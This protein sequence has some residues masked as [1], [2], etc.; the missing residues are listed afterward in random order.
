MRLG[1]LWLAG[2]LCAPA[3]TFHLT[4]SGLG[5][6]AD[7]EQRFKMWADDIGKATHTQAMIAP[8]RDA[9]R[10]RLAELAKQVKADD[11]FVLMLIGHG[12]FDGADYKFNL[13]GPDITATELALLLDRIPATRQMV[14]NMTSCS[15]GASDLL[16]KPTRVV[17]SATKSGTE[18]NATVFARYW[19]EALRDATA[20]TDKNDTV[21]A[22]EAFVFAQKKTQQFYESNKRLATEHAQIDDNR[23]AGV[24]PLLRIGASAAAATDPAK[25]ALLALKEQYEQQI[26]KLKFEKA[27]IPAEMYKTQLTLL[28]LQLA[29]TQE[30]LDK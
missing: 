7:Y 8:T 2:A 19:A 30:A 12:T 10:A 6:E 4:V 18:K 17:V 25:R 9:L 27:Q 11:A 21:S 26:D 24:F 22:Q 3:A 14:V 5:G 29:K 28:L 15:G 20:D 23:L 1:V 13:P 16:R